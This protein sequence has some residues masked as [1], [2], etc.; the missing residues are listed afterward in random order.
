MEV[1]EQ[2]PQ[3]SYGIKETLEILDLIG[4]VAEKLFM[5]RFTGGLSKLELMRY[6]LSEQFRH[7]LSEAI[8]GS[9]EAPKEW[10]DLSGSELVAILQHILAIVGRIATKRLAA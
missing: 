9:S 2:K 1:A 3:E 8:E 6:A 4:L 7:E 10:G 5:A